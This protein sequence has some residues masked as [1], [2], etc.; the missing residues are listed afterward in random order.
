[1]LFNVLIVNSDGCEVKPCR[2]VAVIQC[3]AVTMA[4][5]SCASKAD[6]GRRTSTPAPQSKISSDGKLQRKQKHRESTPRDEY[7][8]KLR[9]DSVQNLSAQDSRPLP[10]GFT[11]TPHQRIHTGDKPN[12]CIE[13]GKT[14]RFA[15]GLKLHQQTHTGE[16]P[17]ECPDCGRSFNQKGNLQEHQL[18]FTG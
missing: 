5:V 4:S 11:V 9:T 16:K 14:F 10:V 3:C 8:K 12:H 13:C 17:Y 6:L 15:T 7:V 1:M 2:K 18:T